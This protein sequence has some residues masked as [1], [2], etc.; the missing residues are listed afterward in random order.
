MYRSFDWG[1]LEREVK[2]VHWGIESL[3]GGT[4]S[5][6]LF[7]KLTEWRILICERRIKGA[8]VGSGRLFQKCVFRRRKR[9]HQG[10]SIYSLKSPM[11]SMRVNWNEPECST[12]NSPI[13]KPLEKI[14]VESCR[15]RPTRRSLKTRISCCY[16]LLPSPSWPHSLSSTYH[17]FLGLLG[18]AS[19]LQSRLMTSS[20]GIWHQIRSGSDSQ[21]HQWG[22]WR[23]VG[24]VVFLSGYVFIISTVYYIHFWLE[25]WIW[26]L[27]HWDFQQTY[28]F[29]FTV[30]SSVEYVLYDNEWLNCTSIKAVC[31]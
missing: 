21:I 16:S 10:I 22:L 19:L 7:A 4:A 26:K 9:N 12:W 20:G 2:C 11:Q 23:K 18:R 30:W 25:L 28:S 1:Y 17:S 5:K 24:R 31:T 14:K 27:C 13:E 6:I 29:R 3:K 15:Q 8:S